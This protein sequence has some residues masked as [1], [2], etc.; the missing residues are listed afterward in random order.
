MVE[1][2]TRELECMYY[3]HSS[4]SE[5][6][7]HFILGNVVGSIF[8][9][10]ENIHSVCAVLIYCLSNQRKLKVPSYYTFIKKTLK[11]QM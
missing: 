8:V 1:I 3:V 5:A 2:V 10:Q 4:Y 6:T 7:V 9:L 11:I